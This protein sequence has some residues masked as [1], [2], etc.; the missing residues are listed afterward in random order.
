MKAIVLLLLLIFLVKGEETKSTANCSQEI[1]WIFQ[2]ITDLNITP[3]LGSSDFLNSGHFLNNLGGYDECQDD[4]NSKYSL[5]HI[6]VPGLPT[7]LT[8]I[9]AVKECGATQ[10]SM[11]RPKI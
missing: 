4:P 7:F 2:N 3:Y 6:S 10:L 1:A 11:V 5:L 8:G 9:C